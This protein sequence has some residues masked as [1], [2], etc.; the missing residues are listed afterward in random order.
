MPTETTCP[1]WRT[2]AIS[3]DAYQ[4]RDGVGVYSPRAVGRYFISGSAALN[5]RSANDDMR[6]KVTH[7][8][9]DHNMLSST[10]EIMTTTIEG[11][12]PVAPRCP[13]KTSASG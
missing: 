12:A 10:P 6:V 9:V 3:L 2:P 13:P 7:E 1:I 5:L 8:I 4:G 11:L